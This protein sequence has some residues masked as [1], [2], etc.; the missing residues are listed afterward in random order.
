MPAKFETIKF[1]VEFISPLIGSTP[2]PE[3]LKQHVMPKDLDK[4]KEAEEIAAM[5]QQIVEETGDEAP[6]ENIKGVTRFPRLDG[7]PAMWDYQWKGYLKSAMTALK[8]VQGSYSSQIVAHRQIIST[9]VAVTPRCIPLILPAGGEIIEERRTIRAETAQGPRICIGTA[10]YA[11]IGT[12]MQLS[13]RYP[14]LSV[15]VPKKAAKSPLATS[16]PVGNLMRLAMIE[17]LDLGEFTVSI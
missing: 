6:I 3:T 15:K 5:Q 14:V 17:V 7:V 10:E 12:K 1:E 4:S 8:R 11:P 16:E 2:D 9:L 13:I